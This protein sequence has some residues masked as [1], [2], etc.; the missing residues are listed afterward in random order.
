MADDKLFFPGERADDIC[1]LIHLPRI[2]NIIARY[3]FI[4]LFYGGNGVNAFPKKEVLREAQSP[5][6]VLWDFN[7][8]CNS[9]LPRRVFVP[10]RP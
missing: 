7:Q 4:V 9:P 8:V 5:G 3:R 6:E 1:A 2:L 10:A